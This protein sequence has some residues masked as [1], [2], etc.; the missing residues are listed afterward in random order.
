M[1][2]AKLAEAGTFKKLL[3]SIRE[4]VTDANFACNEE[5]INLQ[6]MDN[7]HVALVSVH[8][9]ASGFK[10]YRCDRPMPLG[11]NLNTL[12]KVLKCAKDDDICILKAADEA[13]LLNLIYEAKHS[14][15]ISEYDVK[16][17]DIDV[18]TLDIPETDYDARVT[19]PAAEFT[20]IVRDLAQLG[21]NVRIEVSKEGVRFTS[22]GEAANGNVLLKP[23]EGTT[24]A[25]SSSSKKKVKADDEEEDEVEDEED[26]EEA[27]KKKKKVKK[28]SAEDVDM[29]EDGESYKP[30]QDE[31]EEEQEPEEEEDEES[32]KK[33]KR[34]ANGKA[35][36]AKKAKKTKKATD[37]DDEGEGIK[38]EMNSHVSLTFSL[39]YL[40]NFTKSSSLSSKV[41]LM[42][43]NEVPLLVSYDFGQGYIRYYL[44]PKIGDD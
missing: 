13:D 34:K 20:R 24:T 35:A 17:M 2:E 22:E 11:V 27:A 21:E 18:D 29:D 23:P 33:R 3:E 30:T 39:K 15:R 36:P 8:L 10:R 28:E 6:A 26:D 31:G 16:L 44:A 19:M 40:G 1:L 4:L 7:S 37:S 14:D 42:M 25:G 38:I 5:G 43:S 9:M 12:T 41:S 32:G